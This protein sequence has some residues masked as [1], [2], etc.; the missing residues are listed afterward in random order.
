MWALCFFFE[1]IPFWG[2]KGHQK[3]ATHGVPLFPDVFIFPGWFYR[4]A[5]T[6]GNELFFPRGLELNGGKARE[7]SNAGT[8]RDLQRKTRTNF[9]AAFETNKVWRAQEHSGALGVEI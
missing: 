5:V 4:E 6:R 7:P 3:E 2:L 8:I 1:G 9:S